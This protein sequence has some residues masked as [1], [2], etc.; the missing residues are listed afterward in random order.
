MA[1]R[2]HLNAKD[3]LRRVYPVPP[4]HAAAEELAWAHK[5]EGLPLTREDWLLHDWFKAKCAENTFWCH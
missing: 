2:E 5:T 4:T 1:H 3:R